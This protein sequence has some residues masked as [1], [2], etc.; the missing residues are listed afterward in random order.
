MDA[1]AKVLTSSEAVGTYALIVDA[2]DESA[3]SFYGHFDFL[4]FPSNP[5]RLFLPV[6]TIA[7]LFE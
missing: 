7:A 2:K 5:L 1:M 6:A 4:R 3:A